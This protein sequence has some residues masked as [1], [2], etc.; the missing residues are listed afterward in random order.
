MRGS[1]GGGCGLN[2]WTRDDGFV[3]VGNVSVQLKKNQTYKFIA[4][5]GRFMYC[6]QVNMLFLWS[7][8][9][10]SELQKINKQSNY[11]FFCRGWNS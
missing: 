9:E 1:F 2:V 11:T 8:S 3:W 6:S 4:G 10:Q 5:L 7:K